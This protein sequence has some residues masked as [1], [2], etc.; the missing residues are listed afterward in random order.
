MNDESSPTVDVAGKRAVVVG[1]TTGI[2][3]GI[4]RAFAADGADVIATSRSEESVAEITDELRLADVRTTEVTCDV[5]DR[6]S[7]E[8]LR[9]VAVDTL[10]GVD[11]LVNSAGATDHAS[12]L[13]MTDAQW[14]FSV[15][16]LL[17]GVFRACQV[18][19]RAMESGSIVNVS[20]M[21]AGQIREHRPAYCAAKSG[22]NGLTR[23]AAV[24]L[25]PEIRVNAIAPG[26]VRTELSGERLDESSPVRESID[27]RTPLGHIAG[28]E[29]IAGAAVYLASD[30]ASFTTGEVVTVDGGYD[31]S[32][33]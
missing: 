2:G 15:D 5:T 10:G 6:A 33:L 9:D 3:R 13:D 30:A 23:A 17:S 4:A 16:V 1:G 20:S 26:F 24:D 31:R 11:V 22:V 25:A 7:I 8:R 28:T 14:A 21:S 12:L 18:F 19:G 27:Q 29:E 32:A